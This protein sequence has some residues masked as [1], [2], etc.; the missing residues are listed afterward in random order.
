MAERVDQAKRAEPA[1]RRQGEIPLL[2]VVAIRVENRMECAPAV[3]DVL[4]AF[5]QIIA[6][7]LGVPHREAGVSLIT[8]AVDGAK[9]R[10]DEL[11]ERLERIGGVSVK[12]AVW[13][14]E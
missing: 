3:N 14:E 5:G 6:G 11:V 9:A 8:V 2:G 10:V 1:E 12:R 4:T 13:D 7:R